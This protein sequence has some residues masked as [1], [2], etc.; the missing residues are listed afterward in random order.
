MA[1]TLS[2]EE[3]NKYKIMCD[4][5]YCSF[6]VGHVIP[7]RH[8]AATKSLENWLKSNIPTD[9]HERYHVVYIGTRPYFGPKAN[10]NLNAYMLVHKPLPFS[11]D[12]DF[13]EEK[14]IAK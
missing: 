7:F 1:K 8:S 5:S 9:M 10:F 4:N 13:V 6:P 2:F 14:D 3:K 11:Q 12:W